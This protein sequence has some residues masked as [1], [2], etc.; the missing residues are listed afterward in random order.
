VIEQG[1]GSEQRGRVGEPPLVE[2][3]VVR[4]KNGVYQGN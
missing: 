4:A 3:G 2:G 1:I